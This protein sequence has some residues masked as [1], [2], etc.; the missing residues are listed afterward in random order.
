MISSLFIFAGGL[1]LGLIAV[2]SIKLISENIKKKKE[3]ATVGKVEVIN[4]ELMV[5]IDGF[6]EDEYTSKY[7]SI[8][9]HSISSST[10][11]WSTF[12]DY[13]EISFSKKEN[14]RHDSPQLT[15]K[16]EYST[17]KGL[18]KVTRARLISSRG[19]YISDYSIHGN[20]SKELVTT[21]YKKYVEWVNKKNEEKRAEIDSKLKTF[22][23]VL[24][25]AAE[26]DMKLDELLNS[27]NDAN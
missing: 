7:F 24:G 18:F 22:Q 11:E 23:V 27:N 3:A 8:A 9:D 5:E 21:S 19:S 25:K 16:I 14:D 6:D 12:L 4:E 13:R 10:N 17:E 26:R 1:I 15:M 2:P 20:P